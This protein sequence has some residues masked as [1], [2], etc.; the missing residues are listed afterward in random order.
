M[1]EQ[2]D[3]FTKLLSFFYIDHFISLFMFSMHKLS[4]NVICAQPL[5]SKLLATKVNTPLIENVF[6]NRFVFI[7]KHLKK[8]KTAEYCSRGNINTTQLKMVEFLAGWNKVC[9]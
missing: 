4:L 2:N 3:G 8:K 9:I 7:S 1:P 5:M 6:I